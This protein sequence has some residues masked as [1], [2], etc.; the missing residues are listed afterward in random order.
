[1]DQLGC[2]SI[3]LPL[4]QASDGQHLPNERI[5]IE[6]LLKGKDV[7]KWL[8]QHFPAHGEESGGGGGGDVGRVGGGG[9]GKGGGGGGG[10]G[11][12]MGIGDG[13]GW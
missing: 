3:H 11:G 2:G 13:D 10:G 6:N 4:G 5:R 7:I 1:M 12:G 8:L 9:G